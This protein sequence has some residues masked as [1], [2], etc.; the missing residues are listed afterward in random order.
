M[1]NDHVLSLLTQAMPTEYEYL[2]ALSCPIFIFPK[3]NS[4]T[5]DETMA[6]PKVDKKIS[7]GKNN[8]GKEQERVPCEFSKFEP[9]ALRQSSRPLPVQAREKYT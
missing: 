3:E 4:R 9:V 5:L 1:P 8:F 7:A 6:F 2:S